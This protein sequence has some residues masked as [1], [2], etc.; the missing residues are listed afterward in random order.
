MQRLDD[1]LHRLNLRATGRTLSSEAFCR[2]SFL[3]RSESL[4]THQVGIDD[5]PITIPLLLRVAADMVQSHLLQHR[6]LREKSGSAIL[7]P[8][9]RSSKLTLPDSPVPS[10]SS[11]ISRLRGRFDRQHSPLPS[12]GQACSVSGP[13]ESV[14]AET[15]SHHIAQRIQIPPSTIERCH[16]YASHVPIATPSYSGRGPPMLDLGHIPS[17]AM[18]R[19]ITRA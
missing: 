17:D 12:K 13:P 4:W 1:D 15:R 14:I 7:L 18:L 8:Q 11:L 19:S 6:R 5:F 10:S 2:K 3:C 9:S 16:S